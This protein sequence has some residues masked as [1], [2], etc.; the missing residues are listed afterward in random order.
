MNL[1]IEK[2][3]FT[4][5]VNIVVRFSEKKHGSLAALSSVLI[6]AKKD[7]IKMRATN[8]EIGIDI[9]VEGK[10]IQE[11]AVAV[12][13]NIL[14]QIATS[15]SGDGVLTM[16]HTG[17]ILKISTGTGKSSIKTVPY[18]DFPSIPF[19][20]N[21]KN[22]I[23]V[24]GVLLKT[25]FSSIASCAS[26]STI[27][28]ELASIYVSIEGGVLTLAATDSFRLA[29]KKTPLNNNGTQGKFLIPAR[30]ATDIAQALPDEEIIMSFDEN[31]SAFVSTKSMIV[32]RLTGAVYPDYHQIIPKESIVEAIILRKDFES[33]LR[34]TSIFTDSYQKIKMNFDPKKKALIL[35][36]HNTD[37]GDSTETLQSQVNGSQLDISFNHK[38]LSSFLSLTQADSISLTAAGVGRPMIMKGVGDATMLYLVSPMNQ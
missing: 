33:A 22:R 21:S 3:K 8:L 26:T 24:S 20:E 32:S 15:L 9:E 29:E 14:Y 2:K 28:P 25:L 36:A 5:A 11:G 1:S 19:P 30:N 37:V 17:D 38:Y 10:C 27:R 31:Q 13:A 7:E 18:E 4:E 6:I 23:V 35:S 16:D 34:R 12:P